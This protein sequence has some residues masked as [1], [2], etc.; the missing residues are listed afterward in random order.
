M[1]TLSSQIRR[2][3]KSIDPDRLDSALAE[4][5]VVAGHELKVFVE[6]APLIGAMIADIQTATKRVWL[7]SY[8]FAGDSAG[9]AVAEVLKERARAGVDVRVLYDSVGSLSTPSALFTEMQAAGVQVYAFHTLWE[10]FWQL[11]ILRILNRR[12]HRKLLVIDDGVVYFGGMNIVH[13]MEQAKGERVPTS[14]GCR[15]VHVRLVG[16]RQ[17]ELAENMDRLWRRLQKQATSR[18][19]RSWRRPTISSQGENFHFFDSSPGFKHSRAARIFTQ[20]IRRAKRSI[21]LSMAYFIPVA[22]ILRELG[23]ACRRGVLIQVIVPGKSDVNVVQRAS[24]HCYARLLRHGIRIF[25]RQDKM[26]HGKVMIVDNQWTLI[27]SCN[28][29][30]RSLWINRELFAV[31][32]SPKMA[33]LIRQVCAYEMR[34]SKQVTLADCRQRPWWQRLGD[35]AAWSFRWWL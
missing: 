24:R 4:R 22:K 16:P 18:Q 10:A 7:E 34:H 21:T 9:Q 11:S 29:D 14:A 12:H 8:V 35:W 25:E 31:I 30:S 33:A 15:D 1:E 28:L 32:R 19:P 27:G 13:Q 3:R 23:R 17:A 20:L 2:S 6:S 26:L 5:L